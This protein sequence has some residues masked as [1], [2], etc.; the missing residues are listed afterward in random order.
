MADVTIRIPDPR[1]GSGGPTALI[2]V[3]GFA[4]AV[5]ELLAEASAAQERTGPAG[6]EAV[7]ARRLTEPQF[8]AVLSAT[9][10]GADATVDGLLRRVREYQGDR[11][12]GRRGHATGA[13]RM[14]LLRIL[15]L[16]QIDVVWWGAAE[17]YRSDADVLYTSELVDLARLRRERR[18]AFRYRMQ[19]TNLPGRLTRAV[20]RRTLPGRSPHTAGLRFNRARPQLVTVLNRVAAR[21]AEQAP[22]APPLW[23]TSMARSVEHQLRL[24]ALGYPAML[25]SAHCVGYAADLEMAWYRRFG[26]AEA[27][28]RVLR[29]LRA[30]GDVNVIDEGQVWHV[31]LHP[32]VAA[33]LSPDGTLAGG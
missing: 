25:P 28:A 20:V 19:P 26:A 17:P 22:T 18:L 32:D 21:F 1:E 31:C 27:L 8:D 6:S 4:H 5:A 30:A 7:L 16:T 10:S 9:P 29:E 13:D 11:A 23:V 12:A 33:E 14:T 3:E 2:D 15:L 24:A